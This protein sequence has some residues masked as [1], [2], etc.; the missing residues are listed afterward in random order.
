MFGFIYKMFIGLLSFSGSLTFKCMSLN[1]MK[2]VRR[3]VSLL[4]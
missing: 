1:K 2:N 3:D 4:I